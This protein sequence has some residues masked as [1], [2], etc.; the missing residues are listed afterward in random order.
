MSY[1]PIADYGII[2]DMR[3]VALVGM[4]GSI[5]WF[6]AP[7]F[8]SPSI[9][10]ALLDDGQGG[11]FKIAPQSSHFT[12]RQFYFPESNVLVTRFSDGESV[13]QL[14]DFMPVSSGIGQ[15]GG[16]RRLVRHL[17]AIED[18]ISMKLECF[19]AFNYARTGHEIR[20]V[21]GGV[22]FNPES[23]HGCGLSLGDD[24]RQEGNG[25]VQKF[26]LTEGESRTFVLSTLEHSDD[27]LT[28]LTPEMGEELFRATVDYWRGWLSRC[29][30]TG[31]W[32]EAVYRS[33]LTLKLLTYRPTGAVV[34]AA[35][36]SLPEV[37]GGERN[38]DYRYTWIRDAAFTLYAFMRVGLT[39]E[40]G[41]FMDFIVGRVEQGGENGPLDILYGIRGETPR[42]TKTLDHLDGYRSSRPVRIGNNPSTQLQLDIYGELV[43]TVYLFNKYGTPISY[44]LWRAIRQ[45]LNWVVENWEQPDE[46]IWEVQGGRR[47]FVHSKLMC[48]VALDRGIRLADKRSLPADS[49][50][51]RKTRDEI[52]EAIQEHGWNDELQ[53]FV[54][55]F[56]SD[57]LDASTLLMP[58][59]F[60]MSPSDPRMMSTLHAIQTNLTKDSLVYRY[61]P[62]KSPDGLSGQ[63]GTFTI[64]TFWLVEAL[65]RSGHLD[66][67]RFLFERMLGYANHLGLYSEEI[68]PTGELLGNF[69]QAFTHLA[70][71]SAAFNLDRALGRGV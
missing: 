23:G 34:A 64:C 46:G 32:R 49:E 19:P 41:A 36:T 24:H 25:V 39:E 37:I 60:F 65:S 11:Y 12:S 62:E 22:R 4:D 29:T 42:E 10:G 47:Q 27:A 8:D 15:D 33:V 56:G 50:V 70:L 5:D 3:T 2:G 31:R 59:M 57:T 52:Y 14:V 53:S 61:D 13:A 69:P 68:G 17:T 20:A 55:Y 51:W 63:E 71:L 7:D 38:W 67:A 26:D 30:Y 18:G 40:A 28:I 48:W 16:G 21:P 35:T 45:M 58:L 54:Q 1:K 6:C 43:D 9:F 44:D 66:D